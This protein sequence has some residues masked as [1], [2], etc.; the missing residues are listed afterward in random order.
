MTAPPLSIVPDPRVYKDLPVTPW[1]GSWGTS[2]I[3]RALDAHDFGQFLLSAQL[4]ENLQRDDRVMTALNTR[5]QGLLGLPCEITP[6]PEGDRHL[7]RQAADD[8]ARDWVETDVVGALV[9]SLRWRILL[10]FSPT[11]LVWEGD[12]EHW[13]FRLRPWHPMWSWYDWYKR[14]YVITTAEGLVDVLGGAGKWMLLAPEDPY[15]AWI[16]GAVRSIAIPWL[17]RQYAFRD[18]MRFNEIYGTPIRKAVTPSQTIDEDKDRFFNSI[19]NAGAAMVVECPTGLDGQKYDIELVE[20]TATAWETFK[21]A[22]E[23]TDKRITLTLLGQN[24][25]TEVQGGSLAAAKVHG[26]VRQDYLEADARGLERALR[27]Q[28]LRLWAQYNYGDPALAPVVRFKTEPVEDLKASADTLTSFSTAMLNLA[29][30]PE[31]DRRALFARYGLPLDRRDESG[32]ETSQQI[33]QYHLQFGIVTVNE[34]RAALGLPPVPGGDVP[35]QPLPPGTD[36]DAS[37][38]ATSRAIHAAAH[39]LGRYDHVDFAPPAGVREE[40][41]LGLDWREEHGRGGTDVGVARA[42]DLSNGRD[43]SPETARRMKAY[44][45]RHEVDQKGEGWSPGEDG[46]PSAG[47]IAW[48]LWGG[49]P[50]RSWAGKLVRQIEAADGEQAHALSATVQP[51]A[52]ATAAQDFCDDAAS[53]ARDQTAKAISPALKRVLGVIENAGSYDEI[54]AALRDLGDGLDVDEMT[55]VTERLLQLAHLAGRYAVHSLPEE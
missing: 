43:I 48:A 4:A 45:D 13:R 23:D 24:L 27:Q 12:A 25:T 28:V 9:Q 20:A 18:W 19:A 10:G 51:P 39:R 41:Q 3:Q 5:A 7:A 29:Q 26:Q 22:T 52:Q 16:Q 2:S 55:A 34:A 11:E 30:F 33:Y 32:D 47:R 46:Y 1:T 40:A 21:N 8:L 14:L 31:I 6:S 44:F 17:G 35:P 50:G 42:R 53:I 54:R 38:V 49:D 15:R 37:P 36:P